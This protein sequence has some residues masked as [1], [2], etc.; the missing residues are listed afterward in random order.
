VKSLLIVWYSRTGA[1][2]QM[3][4]AAAAHEVNGVAIRLRQAEAA[5]PDDIL[6]AHGL[7]FIT[8]ET[9][10]SMAGAM[11]SFFERCYYPAL[12][13]LNGRP[14]GLMVAAGSD[15]AGAVRG[16]QRIAAGWRLREA[17]PPLIIS[18]NAQTPEAINAPKNLG[19]EDRARCAEMGATFAE[20]LALGVF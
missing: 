5:A 17:M 12:G 10:G 2:R 9:L 14:Y 16:I 7:L 1:A 13:H 6:N 8:P 4:D 11:K 15:G 3:A 18:T 19:A 20:G